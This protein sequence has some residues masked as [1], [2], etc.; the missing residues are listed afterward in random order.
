LAQSLTAQLVVAVVV[1]TLPLVGL[2]PAV[3][4]AGLDAVSGSH[5]KLS[6]LMEPSPA[7]AA[8]VPM[9]LELARQKLAVVV[10]GLVELL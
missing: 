3:V 6:S 10:E 7:T 9:Q 5:R 4:A 8:T 1:L 2:E